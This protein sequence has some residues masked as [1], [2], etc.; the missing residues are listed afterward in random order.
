MGDYP[1]PRGGRRCDFGGMKMII[2]KPYDQLKAVK[3]IMR[4]MQRNLAELDIIV[5]NMQDCIVNNLEISVE[6]LQHKIDSKAKS[7]ELERIILGK[8]K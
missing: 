7:E 4:N 8:E 6:D 2:E 5:N 1:A 3:S